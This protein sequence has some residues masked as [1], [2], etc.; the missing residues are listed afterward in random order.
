M[1][2]FAAVASATSPRQ[3][4]VDFVNRADTTWK[5]AVYPRFNQDKDF[6]TVKRLLGAWKTP[7]D[8]RLPLMEIQPLSAI[9]TD[10]DTRVQW[11]DVCPS[12]KEIRDQSNCGSCWAFGAVEAATD[13][14][15]IATNGAQKPHLSATDLLSCCGFW[16]GSGCDGGYPSAAW[17]YFTSTGVV[18]GGNYGDNAWCSSYPFPICDHHTTGQYQPCGNYPSFSTPVCPNACDGN[19]TYKTAFKDDKHFFKTSYSVS[20]NV[21]DIQ[22]EIMTYGPVEGAFSVYADFESY[23]S[24]VYKHTTGDY[25]GG[26]AIKIIGWGVDNGTPYWTVANSWNSDWGEQGTFRIYRGSDECGIESEIVAGRYL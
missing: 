7:E 23:K 17:S 1:I 6:S 9:P 2:A 12:T 10:Y 8:K 3:Q 25:L 13:R 16:C 4:I 15:C 26:H 19:S 11:G 20:S 24:G 5:A 22:T 18:T 21:A 14:I